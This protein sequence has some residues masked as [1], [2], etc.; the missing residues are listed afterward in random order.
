MTAPSVALFYPWTDIRDE[1]W[2]KSAVL[3]WDVVRT[4][5]PSSITEPYVG[6]VARQLHNAGILTPIPVSSDLP[7][8]EDLTD[9]VFRFLFS[10]EG[11][12]LLLRDSV[13]GKSL[14]HPE[15]LSEDLHRVLMYPD[16]LPS[17]IRK[18][19]EGGVGEWISVDE[20]FGLF[21]MTLLA[22][23]LAEDSG[24]GLLTAYGPSD[25]LATAARSNAVLPVLSAADDFP[26]MHG[27]WRRS[28]RH[29][30]ER[31]PG[32]LAHGL[33]AELVTS[34]IQIDPAVSV[35]KI[36]DFRNT[37]AAEIGRYRN[38][39]SSL[40]E[41][42]NG[43]LPLEALRQRVLDIYSNDVQPA[44]QELERA[45]SGSGIRRLGETFLK[46][47]L[48]STGPTAMLCQA[49]FST[50]SALLAA[51]GISL[52]VSGLLYSVERRAQLEANPYSFLLS[53]RRELGAV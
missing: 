41:G 25:R 42:V 39:L 40:T 11:A 47:S 50:A 37:H 34:Q 51:S 31:V 49:G 13:E 3:Y 12:E 29:Q 33:L 36:L 16:K 2:L 38:A 17:R 27:F 21:Y 6:N 52:A 35:S 30:R 46:T 24:A 28:R 1:S 32:T 20:R 15:K 43:E 19:F 8:I 26:P 53:A 45:L 48:I 44:V 18:L 9:E 23:R 14:L 10:D 5:V 22:T 4:I 7:E